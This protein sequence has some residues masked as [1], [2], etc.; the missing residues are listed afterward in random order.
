MTFISRKL[1]AFFHSFT[2]FSLEKGNWIP[3]GKSFSRNW[4]YTVSIWYAS[5]LNFWQSM[6]ACIYSPWVWTERLD[7][8]E[9][10]YLEIHCCYLYKQPGLIKITL[11]LH[12]PIFFTLSDGKKVSLPFC[13]ISLTSILFLAQM[14]LNCMV[15]MQ[16]LMHK[17]PHA[18]S[19]LVGIISPDTNISV[20]CGIIYIQW[21]KPKTGLLLSFFHY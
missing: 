17:W 12:L 5:L 19:S 3:I 18:W 14:T 2:H 6:R 20:K 4:S 13:Q 9:I 1:I 15:L 11:E 7:N 16:V 8:S 21:F 10:Q